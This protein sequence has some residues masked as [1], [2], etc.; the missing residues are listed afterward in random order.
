MLLS[1]T[2]VNLTTSARRV[3][4]AVDVTGNQSLLNI[5]VE[6]DEVAS[7][8]LDHLNRSNSGR[9]TLMPLNKV[10]G[11][12]V[13]T[14]DPNKAI[15]LADKIKC[16]DKFRHAMCHVFGKTLL[17]PDLDTA[18]KLAQGHNVDCVTVEGEQV[19]LH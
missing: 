19:S 9:I 7:R 12:D 3:D 4:V 1:F 2:H 6:D 16:D 5:L 11:H 14:P 8:I 10:H 15:R 13:K 18:T 17:C